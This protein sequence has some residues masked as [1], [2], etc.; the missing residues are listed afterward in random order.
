M[1]SS[2]PYLIRA[3]YDWIVDNYLTPYVVVNAEFPGVNV[4]KQF[5]EAGRIILNVSPQATHELQLNN[6]VVAFS[7]RF[8]GVSRDISIP[9]PAVLAIYA[10]E[11]GRGMVFNEEDDIDEGQGDSSGDSPPDSPKPPRG[12]P[13]LTIVK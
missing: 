7:A 10:R 2:R 8:S 1:T 9:V 13:K 3:L 11:N 12:K 6:E 4:P 5:V